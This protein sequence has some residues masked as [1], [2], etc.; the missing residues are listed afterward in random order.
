M[1]F[2][3][4]FGGVIAELDVP[5]FIYR[6]SLLMNSDSRLGVTPEQLTGGGGDSFLH[7]YELGH[8][9]SVEVLK[10]FHELCRPEVTDEEIKKVWLSEIKPIKETT[11][12]LL[13]YLRRKGHTVFLLSNTN[14]M[15]WQYVLPMFETNGYK[16]EDHFDRVF[17][18]YRLDMFKPTEEIYDEISKYIPADEQVI[19]IDDVEK[20]LQPGKRRGWMTFSSVEDCLNKIKLS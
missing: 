12:T 7:E 3:F 13:R 8:I 10:K 19:Y 6:L 5:G 11:K 18:S 16:L 1:T 2:I 15:H 4:D 9:S 17:L 14:D 20:N